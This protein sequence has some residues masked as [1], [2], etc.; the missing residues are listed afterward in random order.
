MSAS[1][2]IFKV[3]RPESHHI[4]YDEFDSFIVT[5]HDEVAA[6]RTHPRDAADL[7]YQVNRWS[8]DREMWVDSSNEPM[9]YHSWT[10]D[11]DSLVVERIGTACG[12][13]I[14]VVC[15]SFKAG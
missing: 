4:D 6:R 12:D 7:D 9:M 5:C 3:S 2:G 14:G 1:T 8:D 10:T 15:A 11:I 13:K